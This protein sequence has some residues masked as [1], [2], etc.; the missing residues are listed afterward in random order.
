LA[1]SVLVVLA[2]STLLTR[3]TIGFAKSLPMGPSLPSE[4]T[5]SRLSTWD[6]P[7]TQHK[8][9][10]RRLATASHRMTWPSILMGASGR[11]NTAEAWFAATVSTER[12]PRLREYSAGLPARLARNST[13]S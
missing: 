7:G 3:A 13:G 8:L 2:T 9:L 11:S 4:A 5:A 1:V 12:L 6:S 10:Q